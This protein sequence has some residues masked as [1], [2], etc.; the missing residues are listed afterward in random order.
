V[1]LWLREKWEKCPAW[2]EI[3]RSVIGTEVAKTSGKKPLSQEVPYDW[4]IKKEEDVAPGRL[5]LD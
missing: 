2:A 5:Y 4:S 3:V 1:T